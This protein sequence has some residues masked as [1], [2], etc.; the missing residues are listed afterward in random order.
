M[1]E[2][3]EKY[4]DYAPHPAVNRSVVRMIKALPSV[5]TQGL[6]FVI[7]TNTGAF[8]RKQRS[9]FSKSIGKGDSSIRI[10]S[11][12]NLLPGGGHT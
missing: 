11:F 1:V 4:K 3:V 10:A 2:I 7:L 9:N 12:E 8:N 5:Q 6:K